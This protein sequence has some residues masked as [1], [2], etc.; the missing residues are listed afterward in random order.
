M[1]FS[2]SRSTEYIGAYT[3]G[4]YA[5]DAAGVMGTPSLI[6]G[7]EAA[8]TRLDG[9]SRNRWGDYSYTSIDPNDDMTLWTIQEYASNVGTSNWGTWVASMMAPAPALM[10]V[11]PPAPTFCAGTFGNMLTLNGGNFY[12]PG[13]GFANRLMV[14]FPGGAINGIL[15]TGI[16]WMGPGMVNVF[17]D[18]MPIASAGPRNIMLT[19]PDGQ[20]AFVPNGINILAGP[21]IIDQTRDLTACLGQPEVMCVHATGTPPI[22]YQWMKNG[23]PIPGATMSCY[24][25]PSATCLD[26][27]MY[28][29][30]VTDTCGTIPSM[31]IP[32]QVT[33]PPQIMQQPES[34]VAC[35]GEM[36]NFCVGAFA[37]CGGGI[38]NYQW[39]K[40]WIDI[41]GA[42]NP[43]YDT[44]A[45]PMSAGAYTCLISNQCGVVV[46][47]EARLGV[48]PCIQKISQ[49]KHAP[50][51]FQ[52]VIKGKAV[53]A[54]FANYFYI[55]ETDA[56]KGIR[57]EEPSHGLS[58]G[59]S[60]DI[61]GIVRT[62]TYGERYIDV[63]L[64]VKN[65]SGTVGP[66]LMTNRELG[67]ADWQYISGNGAGQQGVL[68]G[69]GLNNI[70]LLVTSTGA[71]TYVSST[72]FTID[73]GS[74]GGVTV[75]VPSTVTLDSG[76][77]YVTVTGISS[78]RKPGSDVLRW[79]LVRQQS[80]IVPRLP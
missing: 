70:G 18:V 22:T 24:N 37:E 11:P 10:P 21:T 14:M 72:R 61:Q 36:V 67:G 9:S 76:W 26:M 51:G 12:D 6:K 79:L 45:N 29:C 34:R 17:F 52:F 1:G 38:M 13:P 15:V 39:R 30:M 59:D 78:C 58:I 2:G 57:A 50:D 41:P 43:C 63:Q 49:V 62:N 16:G 73:D 64:A 53:A 46:S 8:Y 48:G 55:E 60:V 75:D 27:G 25:I 42:T 33:G 74:M 7:G 71:F 5:G 28:Q 47:A 54:A 3:S 19:N 32:V 68:G 66:L 31:P 65:G 77:Q 40:N 4:R 35:M 80:D 69:A 20:V 23:L 44:I 56:S